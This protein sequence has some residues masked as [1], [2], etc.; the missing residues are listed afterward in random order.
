MSFCYITAVKNIFYTIGLIIYSIIL[1]IVK[2]I[3]PYKYRSKNIEGELALVTGSGSGIGK[4]IAIKLARSGAKLVLVDIDKESNEKTANE[5]L[6]NGGYAKSFICDLSSR[7]NIYK[8]ADE[9]L[10]FNLHKYN[11][12]IIIME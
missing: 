8:L 3:V 7:D 4:L 10:A 11:L 1:C 9:V 6:A 2:Q 5:I 12:I